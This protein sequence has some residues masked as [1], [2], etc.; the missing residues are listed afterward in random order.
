M[1]VT[2]LLS[3]PKNIWE[4]VMPKFISERDYLSLEATCTLMQTN[5]AS[6]STIIKARVKEI[7]SKYDDRTPITDEDEDDFLIDSVTIKT[8]TAIYHNSFEL[9]HCF[10]VLDYFLSTCVEVDMQKLI[11]ICD[12]I[13]FV[14]KERSFVG[15]VFPCSHEATPGRTFVV[16]RTGDFIFAE[17]VD[18]GGEVDES[19][20][21][22]DVERVA[23]YF[24]R[25]NEQ[26]LK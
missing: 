14:D 13:V 24:F 1:Q 12:K 16:T 6:V 25:D 17:D 15:S 4:R 21:E 22:M 10:N 3:I 9:L 26:L 11:E 23:H 2:S 5:V 18:S 8:L 20:E 19:A 7:R